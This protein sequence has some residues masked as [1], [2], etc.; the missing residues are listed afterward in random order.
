MKKWCWKKG[1]RLGI[2]RLGL[3]FIKPGR[4]CS[5]PGC[6]FGIN[7]NFGASVLPELPKVL[8][9]VGEAWRAWEFLGILEWVGMKGP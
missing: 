5:I 7:G 3:G 6:E 1:F 8:L 2:P 9:D 4:N